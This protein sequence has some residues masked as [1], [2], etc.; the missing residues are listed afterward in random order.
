MFTKIEK[1]FKSIIVETKAITWPSRKRIINDSSVV[2]AS[3]VVGSAALAGIDYL[4][5]EL[6]KAA[7]NKIG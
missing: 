2:V 5:L 7:I 3:L 4:F 1:W 6:F